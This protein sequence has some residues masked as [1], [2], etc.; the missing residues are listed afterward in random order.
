MLQNLPDLLVDLP[1][2]PIITTH[3]DTPNEDPQATRWDA[4][5]QVQNVVGFPLLA[6][7]VVE[8]VVHAHSLGTCPCSVSK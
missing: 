5:Q 8:L 1:V 6:G 3:V 2:V 4:H 7:Q